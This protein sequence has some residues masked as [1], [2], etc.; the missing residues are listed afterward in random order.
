MLVRLGF[1]ASSARGQH[2]VVK[3]KP[4]VA[5]GGRGW[6]RMEGKDLSAR[7]LTKTIWSRKQQHFAPMQEKSGG[8]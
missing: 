4:F 1:E 8:V 3:D 7:T 2:R 6:E 5:V